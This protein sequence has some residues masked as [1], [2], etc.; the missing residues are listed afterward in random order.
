MNKGVLQNPEWI[1]SPLKNGIHSDFK[2]L[3]QIPPD[4]PLEKGGNLRIF[5]GPLAKFIYRVKIPLVF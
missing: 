5:L 1:K 2:R 3:F 4:P